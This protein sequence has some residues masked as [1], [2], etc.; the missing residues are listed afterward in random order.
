MSYGDTFSLK[1]SCKIENVIAFMDHTSKEVGLGQSGIVGKAT[2]IQ[3]LLEYLKE[4]EE[5]IRIILSKQCP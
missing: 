5:W 4:E 3:H 2:S 1:K